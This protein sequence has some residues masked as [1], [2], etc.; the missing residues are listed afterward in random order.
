MKK[1]IYLADEE[2]VGEMIGGDEADR[3]IVICNGILTQK[4]GTNIRQMDEYARALI[5]RMWN[6]S[7]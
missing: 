1:H 2:F 3:V 6:Y 5:Q 7:T 4:L